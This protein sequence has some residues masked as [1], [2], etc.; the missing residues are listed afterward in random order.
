MKKLF[1]VVALWAAGCGA[2]SSFDLCIQTCD[3]LRKCGINTDAQFQNCRTDCMNRS[4]ALSDQDAQC[5]RDCKNC[6]TI[7]S[8]TSNCISMECNKIIPCSN[9]VDR[10]CVRK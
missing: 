9:A 8:E 2:P 7:K 6:G 4:G 10:T 1:M 5:D 3:A